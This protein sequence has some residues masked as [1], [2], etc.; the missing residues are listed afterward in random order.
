MKILKLI[1]FLTFS[2]LL[3]AMFSNVHASRG[4]DLNQFQ[5]IDMEGELKEISKVDIRPMLILILVKRRLI[6]L[7]H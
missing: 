2:L 5:E 1:S 4:A 7:A 3:S 6:M